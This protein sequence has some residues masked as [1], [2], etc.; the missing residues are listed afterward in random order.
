MVR[1]GRA[2]WRPRA[3]APDLGR[4][5]RSRMRRRARAG[6]AGSVM[7]AA[8]DRLSPAAF[9]GV[10]E[11]TP[12]P[13]PLPLDPRSP[14]V[15]ARRGGNRRSRPQPSPAAVHGGR[16][17]RRA[18]RVEGGVL[19]RAGA[20]PR[21]ARRLRPPLRGTHPGT[22]GVRG[23]LCLPGDLLRR[24]A[25]GREQRRG[26]APRAALDGLAHRH[27]SRSEP[28][29]RHPSCAASPSRPTAAI[30][31]GPTSWSPTATC[32]RRCGVSSRT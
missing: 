14:H 25:P 32:P 3:P 18:A 10:R 28:A 16:D 22:R 7:L 26:R 23:R 30:R 17:P 29:R 15:G 13:K 27:H 31:S 21:P 9:G 20:R 24:Q 19:P 11:R 12:E 1:G 5:D 4:L 8:S 2:G 6:A